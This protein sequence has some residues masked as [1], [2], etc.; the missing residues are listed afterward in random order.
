M[1]NYEINGQELEF[2]SI[3]YI[4]P[5]GDDNNYGTEGNPIYSLNKAKELVTGNNPAV[6]FLDGIYDHLIPIDAKDGYSS[7]FLSP[8]TTYIGQGKNTILNLYWDR[9]TT[10]DCHIAMRDIKAYRLWF[11]VNP[12][13]NPE[14]IYV[15]ALVGNTSKNVYFYNCCFENVTVNNW[16]L[17]YDN[18]GVNGS[19]YLN[20]IIKSNGYRANN[21]TG[22][23]N[24]F[25]NT[26]VDWSS[27]ASEVINNENSI[28]RNIQETDI[29]DP[30]P[31]GGDL[32]INRVGLYFNRYAWEV[33]IP[34]PQYNLNGKTFVFDFIIYI[35]PDGNDSNDGSETNPVL[36]L[37]RAVA[38]AKS[39]DK[40][41]VF[42]PGEYLNL[43]NVPIAAGWH[44]V[45]PPGFTYFGSQGKAILHVNFNVPMMSFIGP[46]EVY[47]CWL[48]IHSDGGTRERYIA[49]NYIG[50]E[51][52][53][54]FYNCF[55]ET[56][57]GNTASLGWHVNSLTKINYH[58][59]IFKIDQLLATGTKIDLVE[60]SL[61]NFKMSDAAVIMQINNI[62]RAVSIEN[63]V[64]NDTATDLF[65]IGVNNGK[66]TWIMKDRR[67]L[68]IKESQP[69]VVYGLVNS[70]LTQLSDRWTSLSDEQKLIVFL[71]SE[72]FPIFT[73]SIIDSIGESF[74]FEIFHNEVY[75]LNFTSNAVPNN[76]AILP[77]GLIQLIDIRKI[78]SI[79]FVGKPNDGVSKVLFAFTKDNKKYYSFNL[80]NNS[81]DEI[82]IS[83]F[84][85][86]G[87]TYSQVTALTEIQIHD[88]V[89]DDIKLGIGYILIQDKITES[90][91]IDKLDLTVELQGSWRKAYKDNSY[92]EYEYEYSQKI[93]KILFKVEGTYKIT[94][95]KT[96][97]LGGGKQDI[98]AYKYI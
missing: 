47:Q 63:D 36:T 42:L 21:Y 56:V 78:K 41:I 40:A 97:I 13:A 29:I 67:I 66:Y 8:D 96:D 95:M 53:L 12:I 80:V 89:G 91:N 46:V 10:R 77:K 74:H 68:I 60:N 48:K 57:E 28:Y 25:K 76:Q 34:M 5:N 62:N 64:I 44:R 26:L 20:C 45:F 88:F 81:W 31:Q 24:T 2:T 94:Y 65:G 35:S 72:N 92:L 38:L 7:L 83:N 3:I 59:C 73:S 82:D 16:S 4:S 49:S 43:V 27:Y 11:K 50:G 90:V 1:P 23:V 75:S 51:D 52:S 58:N 18:N 79:V 32:Y 55:F 14:G 84:S 87:M 61:S 30:S 9:K 33:I 70:V 69:N 37:S 85:T 6:V 54:N 22:K 98:Y 39:G 19:H 93:L 71:S 86:Q 15:N 17:V